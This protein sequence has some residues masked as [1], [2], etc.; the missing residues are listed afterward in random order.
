MVSMVVLLVV[1]F[2]DIVVGVVVVVVVVVDDGD[3]VYV[4]IGVG[5]FVGY[6][7]DGVGWCR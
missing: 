3:G 5:V 1:L 6:D 2:F 7:V 4:V